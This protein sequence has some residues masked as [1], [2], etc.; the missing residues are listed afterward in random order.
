VAQLLSATAKVD[1]E[2]PAA[3][4]DPMTLLR[5]QILVLASR[6]EES[7]LLRAPWTATTAAD[8]IWHRTHVDGW[9]HLIEERSWSDRDFTD[10]VADSLARDLL[11]SDAAFRPKPG[12]SSQPPA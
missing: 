11:V 3:W 1:P 2:A 6:L 9:G 7:G 4:E 8:W 10:A 12:R 5:G